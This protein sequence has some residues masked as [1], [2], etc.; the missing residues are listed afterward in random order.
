V[1]DYYALLGVS[2]TASETEIRSAYG[3]DALRLNDISAPPEQHALL[4]TA[5]ATLV[6]PATRAAYDQELAAAPVAAAATADPGSFTYARNGALWFAGGCLITALT[7]FA[8]GGLGGRYFIAW[9]AVVFGGIQL[10]RGL[11]AYLASGQRT[12]A[13]VLTLAGL[14]AV[15]VV[16]GGWVVADQAVP[17]PEQAAVRSW[18]ST[19][20]Q[21]DKLTMRADDLL[22][23]VSNRTAWTDQDTTDLSQ[24]ATLYSQ[25]ADLMERASIPAG[26]EWYRDGIVADYREAASTAR[27][28]LQLGPSGTETQ[29]RALGARWD[30]WIDDYNKLGERF[31]AARK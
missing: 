31:D 27:A 9:G 15:G 7:Y 11:V 20:D 12:P 26:Y 23:Q 5:F 29:W 28:M 4:R 14:V 30:A 1:T 13:Q 3:R 8:A 10:V 21:A 2:R 6:D 16:S 19:M 22:D 18:N 25:A 24:V 17:S